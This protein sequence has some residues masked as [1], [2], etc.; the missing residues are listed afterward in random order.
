[1]KPLAPSTHLPPTHHPPTPLLH[2]LSIHTMSSYNNTDKSA[3]LALPIPRQKARELTLRPSHPATTTPTGP[4]ES[5]T[6]T[7]PALGASSP[8]HAFAGSNGES[9][10]GPSPSARPLATHVRSSLVLPRPSLASSAYGAGNQSGLGGDRSGPPS[11][12]RRAS[13]RG[14]SMSSSSA[15]F[16]P[17]LPPLP[18]S[19][20][21]LSGRDTLR[22]DRPSE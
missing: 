10:A 12:S 4:P 19:A 5:T 16:P 20:R 15:S 11:S 6:P 17:S 2:S 8:T 21:T 22:A 13:S 1:M 18:A 3:P 14:A 9:R 7:R